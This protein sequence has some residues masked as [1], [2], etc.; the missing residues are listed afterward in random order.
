V[1]V[2]AALPV[3]V[4]STL[5]DAVAGAEELA[6]APDSVPVSDARVDVSEAT[7]EEEVAVASE[8]VVAALAAEEVAAVLAAE[9]VPVLV[10]ETVAEVVASIISSSSSHSSSSS[11]VI[12]ASGAGVAAGWAI[13]LETMAEAVVAPG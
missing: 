2:D 3:D 10:A 1:A 4:D 13:E 11:S 8:A 9:E 12:P 5:E 7:D 6:V